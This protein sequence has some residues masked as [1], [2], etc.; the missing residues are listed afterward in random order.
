MI[1]GLCYMKAHRYVP[2]EDIVPVLDQQK[3]MVK[4]WDGDG[5]VAV[6][7]NEVVEVW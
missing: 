7:L 6:D 2:V 5:V 3:G 1:L 4:M